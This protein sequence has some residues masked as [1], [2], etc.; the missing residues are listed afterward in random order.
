[1]TVLLSIQTQ[2]ARIR[3]G[4]LPT[5]LLGDGTL[6]LISHPL[7][8]IGTKRLA[9]SMVWLTASFVCLTAILVYAVPASTRSHIGDLLDAQSLAA[10]TAVLSAWDADTYRTFAFLLG[11][12]FLYDVVH[13]NL[14]A[15]FAIWGAKRVSASSALLVASATAWVLWLDTL[16]NVFENLVFL[17]VVRSAQ[18]S[19]LMPLASAIFSFR[20]ATLALGLVVGLGLHAAAFGRHRASAV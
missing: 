8:R 13:N 10:A 6:D 7:Q 4:H 3:S 1:M 11:F 17:D 12:D 9:V 19:P 18:A 16:L 15:V 2:R 5:Q 14:V 20:T